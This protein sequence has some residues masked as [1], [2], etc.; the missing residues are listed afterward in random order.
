MNLVIYSY[1]FCLG[2]NASVNPSPIK[3]NSVTVKKI[4]KPGKIATQSCDF[5]PCA[6]ESN[7]PQVKVSGGIP[8]P[9]KDKNDSVKTAAA[10]PKA[11]VIKTGDKAFGMACFNKILHFG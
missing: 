4:A 11:I 10:I 1:F 8:K 9:I 6:K 3:L 7:L 2:S 5:P